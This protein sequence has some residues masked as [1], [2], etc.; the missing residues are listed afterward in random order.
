MVEKDVN[1]ELK[2]VNVAVETREQIVLGD[3]PVSDRQ[4]LVDIYNDLQQLKK[5]LL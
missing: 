2:V 1:K 4:L 5:G 3:D